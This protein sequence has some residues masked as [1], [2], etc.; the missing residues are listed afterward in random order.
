MVS[1]LVDRRRRSILRLFGTGITGLSVGAGDAHPA[2]GTGGSNEPMT[3]SPG[4]L[5]GAT[6]LVD[7]HD[8]AV[9]VFRRGSDQP[10]YRGEAAAAIQRAI[11]AAAATEAGGVIAIAAGTFEI[12]STVSL[13]SSTWLVGNGSATTLEAASGLDDDLVEIRAGAEH[14]GLSNLRLDGNR[15]QNEHGSGV[16]IRGGT[17]RAILERVI[18]RNAADH[19]IEFSGSADSYS[20]EPVVLDIDVAESGGDGFV[21]GHTGDLFG[22]DLYAEACGRYGFTMAD[23]GSTIVHPHAYDTPGDAGIRILESAKD[24]TL[25]GGHAEG[26]HRRGAIIQGERISLREAFVANNSRASPGEYAGLV[27]DGARDCSVTGSTVVNDRDRDKTQG[28][29][30]VETADSRQNT[31]TDCLFREN[32]GGAV[33]RPDADTGSTYRDNRG[34]RTENGGELTVGDGALIAHGLP[35]RPTRYRADSTDPGVRCHVEQAD[36]SAL[37]IRLRH[38]DSSAV[39]AEPVKVVWEATLR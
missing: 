12:D 9:A 38:A 3:A 23:A 35:S 21:F 36:A 25:I 37:R 6:Y 14:A 29:G 5:A 1:E 11:D 15:G 16:H 2:A 17:W 34:Y 7:Y 18:V 26:N 4:D 20:H 10:R 33:E 31:V 24:L 13:A 22:A 27:L 28:R 32:L 8:G 39:H 30:L 19:G